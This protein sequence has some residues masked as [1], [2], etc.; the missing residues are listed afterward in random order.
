MTMFT[1]KESRIISVIKHVLV[2]LFCLIMI[3]WGFQDFWKTTVGLAEENGENSNHLL[4]YVR[5]L[6]IEIDKMKTQISMVEQNNEF[7]DRNVLL[8]KKEVA[9]FQK[10]QGK[11]V[12]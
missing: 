9:S 3:F 12:D 7:K 1:F 2:L 4:T 6:K 10:L 8:L 11:P 5:D